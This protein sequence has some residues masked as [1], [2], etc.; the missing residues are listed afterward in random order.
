MLRRR[1]K[2][3]GRDDLVLGYVVDEMWGMTDMLESVL[4]AK[5]IGGQNLTFQIRELNHTYNSNSS[6]NISR[7]VD[8]RS[9]SVAVNTR[10]NSRTWGSRGQRT[11]TSIAP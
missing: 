11:K 8:W 9:V 1:E 10:L 3:Y 5:N 2:R 6:R 7:L 4:L